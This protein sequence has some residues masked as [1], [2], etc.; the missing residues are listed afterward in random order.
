VKRPGHVAPGEKTLEIAHLVQEL[1]EPKL[2]HLVDDNE[3]DL[4]VF[5][6][7]RQRPLQG[8][9]FVQFQIAGIGDGH[10]FLPQVNRGL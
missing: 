2:V 8:E 5:G 3:E 1:L 9:Q 10:G 7:V 4:V 6:P